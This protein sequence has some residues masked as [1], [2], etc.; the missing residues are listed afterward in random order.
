MLLVRLAYASDLPTP[1]E[2]LKMLKDGGSAV[3]GGSAAPAPRG[4]GSGGGAAASAMARPVIAASNPQRLAEPA[5][6]AP[7]PARMVIQSLPQLVALAQE[8][9][10]ILTATALRAD[11]RLVRL[12]DGVI[13]FSL[14]RGAD[15]ALVQRLGQK[16][17]EWTGRRWIVSLSNEQGDPTIAEMEDAAGVSAIEKLETEH[18]VVK[19]IKA[20]WPDAKVRPPVKKPDARPAFEAPSVQAI[21]NEDG[22][23]VAG[24]ADVTEDDL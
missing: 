18:P 24:E 17:M 20:R 10:D 16:L 8:K 5:P 7:Q 14:A 19:A 2:A 21:V 9:R 15:H 23:V 22:D 3:T 11:V 12:E 4:G 13:E 6:A 1:D